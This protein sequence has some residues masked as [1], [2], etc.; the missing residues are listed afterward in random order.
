MRL[1]EECKN[2]IRAIWN[3]NFLSI[4]YG[5]MIEGIPYVKGFYPLLESKTV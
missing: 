5:A 4:S 2:A 3:S 1:F